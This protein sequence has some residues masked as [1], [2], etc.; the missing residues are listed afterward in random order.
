[1][2]ACEPRGPADLRGTVQLWEP[3]GMSVKG[4]VI[5]TFSFMVRP[6]VTYMFKH[7]TIVKKA[8]EAEVGAHFF[9]CIP[10]PLFRY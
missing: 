8:V 7:T 4:S 1:M 9:F 6:A 3:P 10:G 5:S 2:E